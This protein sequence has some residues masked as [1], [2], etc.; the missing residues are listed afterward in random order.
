MLF[1]DGFAL[2]TPAATEVAADDHSDGDANSQPDGDVAGK[3]AGSGAHTGAQ[4]NAKTNLG[5]WFL[6]VSAFLP[7]IRFGNGGTGETP[8]PQ[9][10]SRYFPAPAF[11]VSASG[12]G[13]LSPI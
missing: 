4:C 10:L 6:H 12:L 1:V 7:R 9:L 13:D 11:P 2:G 8:V 5:S 3:D